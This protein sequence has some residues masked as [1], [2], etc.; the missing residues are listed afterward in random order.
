MGHDGARGGA[1][2]R[3]VPE[4]GQGRCG[5]RWVPLPGPG[6]RRR[7]VAA[8]QDLPGT[9]RTGGV[10]EQGPGAGADGGFGPRGR[11]HAGSPVPTDRAPDDEPSPAQCIHRRHD[12]AAVAA[13]LAQGRQLC[14][15][16]C[17]AGQ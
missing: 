11:Y 3:S 17:H 6:S 4:D 13:A 15:H 12:S 1:A 7:A 16:S 8:R 9:R 2:R 10:A 14:I 5:G